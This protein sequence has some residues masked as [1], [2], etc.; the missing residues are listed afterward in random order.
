MRMPR[1]FLDEMIQHAMDERPNECCGIVASKN[2]EAVEL[3][4]AKSR[5]PSPLRYELDPAEQLRIMTEID[6][7]G[8]MLGGIYH[9]HIKSPAY[10]SQTDINLAAYPDALYIIVSLKDAERPDVRG[11]RIV[12]GKIDEVALTFG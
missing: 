6:E 4:R 8:W 10:P 1:Q 2:G 5:N 11:F 3:Y 7:R 9:S 12:D